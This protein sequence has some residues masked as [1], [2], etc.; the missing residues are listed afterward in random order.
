LFAWVPSLLRCVLCV[1]QDFALQP[2]DNAFV[3][4]RLQL[5]VDPSDRAAVAA[6]WPPDTLGF[7]HLDASAPEQQQQLASQSSYGQL[8]GEADLQ[9]QQ[10]QQQRPPAGSGSSSVM[11]LTLP[12]LQGAVVHRR[13]HDA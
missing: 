7:G 5:P 8:P 6:A 12:G 9:P 13:P 10:P 3:V 4:A 2:D 1:L 11:A